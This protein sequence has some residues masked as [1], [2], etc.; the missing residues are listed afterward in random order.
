MVVITGASGLLGSIIAETFASRKVP[1][2]GLY[3]QSKPTQSSI[4]WVQCDVTDYP[5][6]VKIV[7]NAECVIH[8]AAIVSFA[9]KHKE[10]MFAINVD[11]TANVVNASL[12]AGVKR[13]VHISSVAAIGKPA[14][15]SILT[16]KTTWTHA[17]KPSNYG[18]SKHLAELE[19]FRGEA[20]G[21]SVASVNPS[22]IL[23]AGNTHRSSGKIIQYVQDERPFYVDGYL[24]YVDARDVAEMVWQLYNNPKAKGRY[25]ASAGTV[26][27]HDLF[28]GIGSRLGKKPPSI[29]V[30]PVM[31]R[32]AAAIEWIRSTVMGSEPLI[33]KET[34]KIARQKITYSN[35]RA[36]KDLGIKFRSL[37]DTL[38][39]CCGSNLSK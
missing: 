8:V 6:L 12:A 30:S 24:N 17:S 37:S 27:W 4:S 2:T 25:I 28:N 13:L 14:N 31:A 18:Q 5:T 35:D 26:T 36:V 20:E 23:A 10:K 16:E 29:K 3:N 15:E 39:W 21:L 1:V 22:I 19:A 7:K 33:T 34:A 38:D 32:L 11:G 9:Q